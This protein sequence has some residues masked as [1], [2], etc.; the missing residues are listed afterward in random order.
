[1]AAYVVAASPAVD[2]GFAIAADVAMACV[3]AAG[4]ICASGRFLHLLIIQELSKPAL[5]Y[6]AGFSIQK[7][8]AS[9]GLGGDRIQSDRRDQDCIRFHLALGKYPLKPL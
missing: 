5:A 7:C 8:A 3:A 9:V 1:M 6:G 2:A 4:N